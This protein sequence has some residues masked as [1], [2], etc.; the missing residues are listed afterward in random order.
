MDFNDFFK[1][2]EYIILAI[3]FYFLFNNERHKEYNS[4]IIVIYS[5]IISL[6]L[7]KTF[8]IIGMLESLSSYFSFNLKYLLTTNIS[9]R[10]YV[11]LKIK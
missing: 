7:L 9:I 11:V 5:L 10:L 2:N 8:N 3:L 6:F 4:K 1:G